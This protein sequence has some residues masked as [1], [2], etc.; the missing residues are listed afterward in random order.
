MIRYLQSEVI[1]VG[2]HYD[3]VGYGNKRNSF[4]PFGYVHNGA[5]DNASG[6]AGSD[7]N[8]GDACRD[9]LIRADEQFYSHSGMVKSKGYLVPNTS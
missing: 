9:C 6:V 5:D 8:S 4:G 1:V 2:A 3:H 7:Q